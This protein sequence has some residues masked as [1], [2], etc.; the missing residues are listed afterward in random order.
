MRNETGLSVGARLVL[1][2]LGPMILRIPKTGFGATLVRLPGW[3]GRTKIQ[4]H[5]YQLTSAMWNVDAL[6]VRELLEHGVVSALGEHAVDSRVGW[7]D[8]GL[9]D[10]DV[11]DYYLCTQ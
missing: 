2:N 10:G 4:S 6:V 11:A 3:R 5:H 9:T 7:R 1:T 8:L